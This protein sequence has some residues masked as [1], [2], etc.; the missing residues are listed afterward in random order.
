MVCDTPSANF[1]YGPYL[2]Q[3]LPTE[4]VTPSSALVFTNVGTPI[5]A[6]TVGG[7]AYDSTSGQF[8]M[9]SSAADVPGGTHLYSQH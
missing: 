3:G 5:A 6:G 4:P 1:K 8:I 2:R 9:N 7:W